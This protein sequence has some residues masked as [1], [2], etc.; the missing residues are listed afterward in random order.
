M[1]FSS[2]LRLRVVI[3]S[4]QDNSALKWRKW[5]KS[6]QNPDFDLKHLCPHTVLSQQCVFVRE[7]K[8]DNPSARPGTDNMLS[9][10]RRTGMRMRKEVWHF[11]AWHFLNVTYCSQRILPPLTF[12]S[13]FLSLF[14]VADAA[15]AAKPVPSVIKKSTATVVLPDCGLFTSGSPVRWCWPVKVTSHCEGR[16]LEETG[17]SLPA[18]CDLISPQTSS[19]IPLSFVFVFCCLS[20][21]WS[22]RLCLLFPLSSTASAH[23]ILALCSVSSCN[24]GVMS[25]WFDF[26]FTS[27]F[28][29]SPSSERQQ[30]DWYW[31]YDTVDS[32]PLN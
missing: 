18:E 21:S 2:S 19:I 29:F 4:L 1:Y 5:L 13:S 12:H 15:A 3:L 17:W 30:P 25:H 11:T 16:V 23:H 14:D 28:L 7:K 9:A 26:C 22:L 6:S 27:T 10:H 32:S 8:R 20:S 24:S 31:R